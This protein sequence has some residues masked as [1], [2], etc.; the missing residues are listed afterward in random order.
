MKIR[1]LI[2]GVAVLILALGIPLVAQTS[3]DNPKLKK[4]LA[5]HP[6]ADADKDGILTMAEA[7]AFRDAKSGGKDK[8]GK[9]GG[10][11]APEGGERKVYKVVGDVKLPLYVFSPE[12]AKAGDKLPA[13]VFFFGGG[14]STG[15]PSQFEPQCK[16]LAGRGMVAI[17]VEYRVSSRHNA[18][19][20][21]CIEDAKSAMR[22]VRGHAGELGIDPDRIASGGGS[23]GGHLAAC[24]SVMDDFNAKTDDLEVSAKPDA[25][26]LFNPGMAL[27]PHEGLSDAYLARIRGGEGGKRS[28]VSVEKLSPLTYAERKQAPCI[29]FFGTADPLKEGADLYCSVSSKAGN[30]CKVVGYEGQG[31][32]FFNYNSGGG[33]YYGLTLAE[34]DKFLVGLGWLEAKE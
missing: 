8:A 7:K 14:W 28:N 27:A 17:T 10:A 24:V 21:D 15:G 9:A 3:E 6:E 11:T 18:K 20:E 13:I 26:V 5:N 31:H 4:A 29:M 19:I 2:G 30:Q 32:G 23:A 33:K 1:F 12:G 34:M 16:Y 22:W 25:M